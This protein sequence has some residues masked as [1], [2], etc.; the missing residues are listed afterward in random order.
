MLNSIKRIVEFYV[1]SNS[2]IALSAGIY[3]LGA[4]YLGH[5]SSMG[6]LDLPILVA[7]STYIVYNTHRL[8]GSF[9]LS[10]LTGP[11]RILFV[12]K[13]WLVLGFI[14]VGL[15][16]LSID[17]LTFIPYSLWYI[18][19]PCT[20]LTLLYLL[21]VL[22]G[23][24]RLRD[25]PLIK[26]LIIA[27]VWA[28]VFLLPLIADNYEYAP[29]ILTTVFIEK[30]FFFFM[31]T[32]PFDYRDK[33]I[34]DDQGTPT[35]ATSLSTVS[36]KRLITAAFIVVVVAVLVLYD[37]QLYNMT[38]CS[39]LLAT[40]ILSLILSIYGINDRSELYYL[41]VLDGMILLNGAA[42]LF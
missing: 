7:I 9:K 30:I 25:L 32:I 17:L 39:A 21:P 29:I 3:V 10:E 36:L 38:V 15:A 41:G 27:I 4:S 2:H 1:Y 16:V 8:V 28:G 24:R 37:Y 12:K 13:Y 34:D 19:I 23:R 18:I 26:I 5:M 14:F 35:L 31:I 40:Y 22:P 33:A 42:Y 6:I 11:N 20:I